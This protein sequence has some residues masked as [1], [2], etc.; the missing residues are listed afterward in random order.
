MLLP[1]GN[2][3]DS[4]GREG[5]PCG[6]MVTASQATQPLLGLGNAIV[7]GQHQ[8]VPTEWG[9]PLEKLEHHVDRI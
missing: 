3:A 1:G 8:M 7:V 6:C 4:G 2:V 9:R 5:G